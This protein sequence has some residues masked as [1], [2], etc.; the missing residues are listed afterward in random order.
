[1]PSGIL[2]Q[3][4]DSEM[5]CHLR[6]GPLFD[7]PDS[8]F[9]PSRSRSVRRGAEERNFPASVGAMWGECTFLLPLL[10]APAGSRTRRHD[11]APAGETWRGRLDYG[12]MVG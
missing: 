7:P 8:C 9:D 10:T 2:Q 5:L 6:H 4:H 11:G 1:M 12:V 3:H